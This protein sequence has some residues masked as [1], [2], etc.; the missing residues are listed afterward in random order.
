MANGSSRPI[1]PV[2]PDGMEILFFY[3]CPRCG[4]HVAIASPTEPRMLVCDSCR[5]AFPI[6]PV[7][8]HGIHYAHIMLAGGKAAAD[9][10]F[11]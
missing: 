9:P 10:D 4:E 3:K 2:A 11:L 8:E 6:I 7:D 5:M 1:A